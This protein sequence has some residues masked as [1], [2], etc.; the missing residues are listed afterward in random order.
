[1]E[2][3]NVEDEFQSTSMSNPRVG[4]RTYLVTY[5]KADINRF[6]TRESFGTMLVKHF[7][8]EGCETKV[9]FWACSQEFHADGDIHYHAAL[10]LN[11]PKKWVSVKKA[12][13]NEEKISVHFSDHHS[14]YVAAYRYISKSDTEVFHSASH[15]NLK[16]IA[17]PKTKAS[18]LAYRENRKQKRKN[19]CSSSPTSSLL[20]SEN[21]KEKKKPRRLS[22]MD[23]S[24]FLIENKIKNTTELYAV[25]KKRK[26]EGEKDLATFVLS[27]SSKS[28]TE[29]IENSWK[30]ENASNVLERNKISRIDLMR[31]KGQEPCIDGCDKFWLKS[32]VEVLNKNNVHPY[33]YA[34]AVRDAI[35]KGRGK[36]R[37]IML[38]GPTNCGKTFMLKPLE[39]IFNVFSNPANDK[40]G[41]VGAD[42]AELILLQDFRWSREGITWKDLLLLLEGEIVKLPAPKNHFST[43]VEIKGDIPIFATSKSKICFQ[44]KGNSTDDCETEMM[45]VRWKYFEFSYQIPQDQ[46]KI[47]SPC[48]RCFVELALM[49]ETFGV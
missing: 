1:M 10:K 37:N 21:Q 33:V 22:N 27:R 46:Q 23:V 5:S 40:Y 20:S 49:G 14:Y 29:L 19:D 31:Q 17:S 15:P 43:D 8:K 2:T 48:A 45:A 32:A 47:I 25:A 44:G 26:N 38:I 34:A 12:I 39:S 7:N 24:D 42:I 16:D 13:L 6:P 11:L 4:R 35:I 30:M 9:D 3:Q 28:I 41:W 36:F 18:T